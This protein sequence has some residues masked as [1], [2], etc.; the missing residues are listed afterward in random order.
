MNISPRNVIANLILGLALWLAPASGHAAVYG[1]ESF[2]LENGMQVVVIP[3]H[4]APVV[5]HMV[6]YRGG[7]IDEP[8]G[9]SGIAH[10]LEHLM[11]KGTPKNP[12]GAINRI[13]AT[14][15]GDQNAFTSHDYTAYYQNIAVDRLPIMMALE[16]DRMKNL[17]LSEEDVTT[18]REVIIEERRMRVSNRPESVLSERLDAAWWM[19]HRYGIP[20]LGWAEEMANLQRA[21]ALAF[22]KRFYSPE[23]AILVVAGDITAAQLKPL[24]E[25]TYGKLKRGGDPAKH[26]LVAPLPPPASV[27]VTYTDPRV[28]QPRWYR[29]FVAPSV[30]AGDT[31]E[32]PALA[33]FAEILGGG[34]TSKLYRGLVIDQPVGA[35]VGASYD[36]MAVSYGTFTLWIVPNPGV[37]IED[38]E[39]AMEKKIAAVLD[40]GITDDDVAAAKQRMRTSLVYLKDSPFGAAQRVGAML[41]TGMTLE[42]IESSDERIAAV[43]ADQVRA[44]AKKVL[45]NAPSAT[46]ILLP[47]GVTQ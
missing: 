43:T 8:P 2:M 21:D 3:N 14:N 22:Y 33:V 28:R 25:K 11:F 36:S 30:N 15:G 10:F 9:K 34:S 47:E 37:A 7:A 5:T 23:N 45:A 32:V 27:R 19:T 38:A 24:A 4:R 41:A 16:A 46:G 1:A 40:G 29:Q 35:G 12:E 44:A 13:V 20:V 18:E 6:W 42:Q 17:I 31:D 26:E 39:A